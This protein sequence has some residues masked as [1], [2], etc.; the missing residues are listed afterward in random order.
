MKSAAESQALL[1]LYKAYCQP[2]KCLDCDVGK[3]LLLPT[4]N[5][6]TDCSTTQAVITAGQL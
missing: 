2:K 1:E 6:S 4:E 5:N 3:F